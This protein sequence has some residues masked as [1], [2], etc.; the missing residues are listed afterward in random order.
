MAK[1]KHIQTDRQ[2]LEFSQH[3]IT[4]NVCESVALDL[5]DHTAVTC[6]HH[7]KVSAQQVRIADKTH[8]FIGALPHQGW[9][10]LL[11]T[12]KK[13]LDQTQLMRNSACRIQCAP[14][15]ALLSVQPSSLSLSL[16]LSVCPLYVLQI[17][18]NPSSVTRQG[19]FEQQQQHQHQHQLPRRLPVPTGAQTIGGK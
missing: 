8:V 4:D 1:A 7:F 13:I 6:R 16:C 2:T 17:H 19:H 10:L 11:L 9:I 18:L 14:S 5:S 15:Y 12:L 3:Q